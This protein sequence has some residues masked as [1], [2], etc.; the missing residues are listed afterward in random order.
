MVQG[1]FGG[2]G[3]L[4]ANLAGVRFN[5][6][7]PVVPYFGKLSALDVG[8]V[9]FWQPVMLQPGRNFSVFCIAASR[10]DNYFTAGVMPVINTVNRGFDRISD[11]TISGCFGQGSVKLDGNNFGHDALLLRMMN[12]CENFSAIGD[13]SADGG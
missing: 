9:E 10:K 6:N 1:L 7:S 11:R 13:L 2:A 12:D 3:T 4:A 5:P 8:Y